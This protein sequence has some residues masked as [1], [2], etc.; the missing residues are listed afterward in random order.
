MPTLY[1]PKLVSINTLLRP[2]VIHPDMNRATDA[3]TELVAMDVESR[4][5]LGRSDLVVGVEKVTSEDA[6][7]DT[8]FI[9]KDVT[10]FWPLLKE[11]CSKCFDRWFCKLRTTETPKVLF[12]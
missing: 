4:V 8:F 1:K 2:L 3:S 6:D 12:A 9:S 10:P 5:D 11:K 7:R